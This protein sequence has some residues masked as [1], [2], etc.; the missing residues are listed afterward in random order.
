MVSTP[1][2][3]ANRLCL[4]VWYYIREPADTHKY[5]LCLVYKRKLEK[6]KC[7]EF[8]HFPQ[9]V[10]HSERERVESW[11]IPWI[12]NEMLKWPNT[13]KNSTEMNK[14]IE[15]VKKKRWKMNFKRKK[16]KTEFPKRTPGMAQCN[17]GGS[18]AG[19]G[20]FGQNN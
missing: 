7:V 11:K 20:T 8:L 3:F 17:E 13:K 9:R 5:V 10:K 6:N 14:R 18:F 2:I 19:H 1:D 15:F 12:F 16:G 4:D